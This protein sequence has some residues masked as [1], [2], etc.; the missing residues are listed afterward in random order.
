MNSILVYNS[1]KRLVIN[2][3]FTNLS[4]TRKIPLTDLPKGSKEIN[5]TPWFHHASGIKPTRGTASTY[6]LTLDSNEYLV[7]LVAGDIN[8]VLTKVFVETA[9]GILDGY[10]FDVPPNGDAS[11][12]TAYV[13]G[14]QP[15]KP[16]DHFGL[17]VF[18]AKGECIYDSGKKYLR[19][20]SYWEPAAGKKVKLGFIASPLTEVRPDTNY[21][22]PQYCY[23]Y[24]GSNPPSSDAMHWA[25]RLCCGFYKEEGLTT[26]EA[27]S[28]NMDMMVCDVTN[29]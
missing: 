13:F 22:Y 29:M 6:K 5:I 18:N 2:D 21:I 4:L 27:W 9:G 19:R 17:H 7:A 25:E 14:L 20:S 28:Y 12:I 26:S 24:S 15:R 1:N 16:V 8:D 10:V 23:F 11:K 3:S